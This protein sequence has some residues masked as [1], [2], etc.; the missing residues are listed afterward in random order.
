MPARLLRASKR[1][2]GS[3]AAP[4]RPPPFSLVRT[5]LRQRPQG[6]TMNRFEYRLAASVGRCL[7]EPNLTAHPYKARRRTQG[8]AVK[9]HTVDG[10]RHDRRR[11]HRMCR[12]TG[13]LQVATSSTG[14]VITN[15]ANTLRPGSEGL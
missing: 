3:V 12:E 1:F 14:A 8:T 2:N 7:S 10:V 11:S 4:R 15:S 9:F 6:A 5:P 13:F